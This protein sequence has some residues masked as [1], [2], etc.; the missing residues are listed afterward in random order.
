MWQIEMACVSCGEESA[1]LRRCTHERLCSRC[2]GLPDY[3]ILT[4]SQVLRAANISS[5]ELDDYLQ[6]IGSVVNPHDC[7][8]ARMRIY[9]WKDVMT[10]LIDLGRDLPEDEEW[11]YSGRRERHCTALRSTDQL[12]IG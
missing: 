7:K 9:Y 12:Q 2:R 6:A 3:K 1:P 5:T 4:R 10:L 8:F 11:Y